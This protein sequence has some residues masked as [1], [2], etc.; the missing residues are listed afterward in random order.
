MYTA[1][2][3]A[4]CVSA[5]TTSLE[6]VCWKHFTQGDFHSHDATHDGP[7]VEKG[8]ALMASSFCMAAAPDSVYAEREAFEPRKRN[9]FSSSSPQP[10]VLQWGTSGMTLDAL[11]GLA[12]SLNPGD[13]EIAPVQ[14]WFELASRYSV[15][16]LFAPGVLDTLEREFKGVV[17]C[18]MFGAA[19]ERLSFESV[20]ARVLGSTEGSLY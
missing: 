15:D 16:V 11:Y 20:I 5:D 9:F 14:A 2:L 4:H 7:G 19:I 12:M 8:H 17:R 13:Q 1:H 18:V 3:R 10:P 6:H